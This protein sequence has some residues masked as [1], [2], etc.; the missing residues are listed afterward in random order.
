MLS[1]CVD[2]PN[3]ILSSVDKS[4]TKGEPTEVL[5]ANILQLLK[6]MGMFCLSPF[7]ST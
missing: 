3:E 1:A 2:L 4:V 6:E 7:T 5:L